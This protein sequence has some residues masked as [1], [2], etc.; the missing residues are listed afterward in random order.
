MN[1]IDARFER[2]RRDGRKGFVAFITAGD[3]TLATT[4]ELAN[5]FDGAGVDVLEL[6][7]P[8]SDPLADGLVNQRA[9]ERAL[10][11][12]VSLADVLDAVR[13]I[14]S[15]SEIPIV[16]FTYINP[17]MRFGLDAFP[18]AAREA[19]LDGILAL[20]YPPEESAA[21]RAALDTQGLR[22]V[23]LIAPTTPDDRMRML[24]E[25]STGF[26]YCVSRTGVTGMREAVEGS[27][28][29]MVA[30][31]K[32]CSAKPVAVGFGISTPEQVAHVAE[33]ADGVVVGSAI[34]QRIE[35]NAGRGD[36]VERVTAFVGELMAPLRSV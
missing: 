27:V 12:N 34:V 25:T 13:T 23:Q 17:V 35:T 9:A 28:R 11:H 6:G 29:S 14:R 21:F 32:S 18:K 7:V 15:T 4:I 24:A 16:L 19:G 2:L 20:D 31:I 26:I 3:P 1:R 36:L 8:F 33:S 5:A 30:R 10:R 22:M